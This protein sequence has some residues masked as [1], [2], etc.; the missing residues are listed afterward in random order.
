MEETTASNTLS[1]L[2]GLVFNGILVYLL[3]LQ[4]GT[5]G[6]WLAMTITEFAVVILSVFCLRA[7]GRGEMT[8]AE[9]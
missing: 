5:D 8:E 6:I 9:K 2:R 7:A 3:P 4:W 1:L